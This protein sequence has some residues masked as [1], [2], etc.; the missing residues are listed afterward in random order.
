MTKWDFRYLELAKYIASWSKD[1]STQT[2]AVIV[3]SDNHIVSVGF[4]GFPKG[5]N[6]DPE[7]YANRDL[8]YKMILHCERVAMLSAERSVKGCTLYTWPFISCSACAAMV[9]QSG[10]TRCVAP[11]VPDH[12]KERWAD[13]MA[14]STQMFAE[15]GVQVDIYNMVKVE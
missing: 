11:P 13:D 14:L 9:I 3:G 6:D 1:P 2:G 7:R 15:A 4:N 8:K 12:L 5:V 10:I